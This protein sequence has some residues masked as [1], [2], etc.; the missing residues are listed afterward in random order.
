MKYEC[1]P[2]R[3]SVEEGHHKFPVDKNEQPSV[4][5][6]NREYIKT[7]RN[8]VSGYTTYV[9]VTY[10]ERETHSDESASV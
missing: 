9:I 2:T 8:G 5:Y 6:I 10:R 1:L 7:G 3:Y 4:G